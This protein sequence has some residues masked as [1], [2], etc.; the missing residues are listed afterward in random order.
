MTSV[1]E[2]G[3]GPNVL[4]V[5]GGPGFT[6]GY[7]I[8]PLR[9][10]SQ[11]NRLIFYDQAYS[12]PSLAGCA[13]ELQRLIESYAQ[14]GG[15]RIVAH[16]WGCL[17]ALA[18]LQE[19]E[20]RLDLK[21][22]I[23]RLVFIN[24]VPVS[25]EKFEKSVND[26]RQKVPTSAI[27]QAAGHAARPDGGEAAMACLLPYYVSNKGILDSLRLPLSFGAYQAVI[28][29][30]PDF[31]YRLEAG[32]FDRLAIMVGD[33]DI[34]PSAYLEELLNRAGETAVIANA[35]HFPLHEQPTNALPKLTEWLA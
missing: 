20:A 34:T 1:T 22:R 5:H 32:V 31:S 24:P 7:L 9:Q 10:L 19:L 33:G 4:V 21:D 13:K 23:S 15:L 14:E 6:S 11:Q 27:E 8:D 17:V 3:N 35:G 18:A 25:K 12:D 26:F 30:L 28:S 16:S 2:L 29:S